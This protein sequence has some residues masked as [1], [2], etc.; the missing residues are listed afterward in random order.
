MMEEKEGEH[1][2]WTTEKESHF[3]ARSRWKEE[4]VRIGKES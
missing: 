3:L 4:S 1:V 2:G